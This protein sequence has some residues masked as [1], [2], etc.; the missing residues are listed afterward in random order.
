MNIWIEFLWQ[1][2]NDEHLSVNTFLFI[3]LYLAAMTVEI[4]ISVK[5]TFCG[6]HSWWT[7]SATLSESPPQWPHF[8]RLPPAN[9]RMAMQSGTFPKTSFGSA[10]PHSSGWDLPRTARQDEPL[11]LRGS[12]LSKGSHLPLSPWPLLLPPL[13]L[14]PVRPQFLACIITSRCLLSR[15][16]QLA[17]LFFCRKEYEIFYTDT[18]SITRDL[19]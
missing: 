17:Q 16:L 6:E 3:Y 2:W 14:S 11:P 18:S 4:D 9:D 19:K 15:G 13:Y 7:A 5:R 8:W 1:L 10:T 12:F